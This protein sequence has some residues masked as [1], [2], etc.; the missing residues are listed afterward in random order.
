MSTAAVNRL[1]AL[2]RDCHVTPEPRRV[3]VVS[4]TTLDRKCDVHGRRGSLAPPPPRRDSILK[5]GVGPRRESMPALDKRRESISFRKEIIMSPRRD[6]MPALNTLPNASLFRR[7]SIVLGSGKRDSDAHPSSFPASLR[8]DSA[9]STSSLRRD[10][11][12]KNDNRPI[13]AFGSTLRR[14]SLA[15]SLGSLRRDS[16]SSSRRDSVS[17]SRRDSVSSSGSLRRD[18][19]SK[20]RFSTDSLDI[21]RNSWDPGRRNSS[22]SS[23]GYD[24]PIW[25]ELVPKVFILFSDHLTYNINSRSF[26]RWV[27]KFYT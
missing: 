26:R 14:D 27:L 6:S 15:S 8:R 1:D 5:G 24:D 25:E 11:S 3:S 21:R 13:A 23:G 2:F 19:V 22:G 4:T 17:S 18:S 12:A 7:D 10:G 9:F 16:I 20:R